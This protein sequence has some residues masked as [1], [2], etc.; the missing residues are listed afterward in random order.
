MV[1]IDALP[2]LGI[3]DA[4]RELTV[5]DRETFRPWIST[6]YWSKDRF[7]CM[8]TTICLIFARAWMRL[9]SDE[10]RIVDGVV[11]SAGGTA[12]V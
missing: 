3:M 12:E 2:G 8:I 10:G 7:S 9:A 1:W 5:L 4:D 11:G 6:K